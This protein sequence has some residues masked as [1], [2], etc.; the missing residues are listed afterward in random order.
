MA[1]PTHTCLACSE[2]SLSWAEAWQKDL[3]QVV[4]KR[5]MIGMDGCPQCM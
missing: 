5:E 3:C 1:L 2:P 4:R